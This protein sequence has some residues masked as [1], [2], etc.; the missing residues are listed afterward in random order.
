[1]DALNQTVLNQTLTRPVIPKENILLIEATHDL[2]VRKEGVEKLW[3]AWDRP[4]IWR[5]PHGFISR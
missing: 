3:Q 4:E 2:L 5:L 1:M